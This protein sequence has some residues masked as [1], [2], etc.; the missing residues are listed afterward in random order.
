MTYQEALNYL[1]KETSEGIKPDLARISY[2]CH[3]L[4][5]PQ[6][7]YPTIHITGTN[8]KTTTARL[9]SS[10]LSVP[11]YKVGVFT[12]P[13]LVSYTERMVVEGE[14]IAQTKFAKGIE[15]LIP[16]FEET[17][18]RCRDGRLTQFEALT[19]LA[20]LFFQ[21]EKVDCAVVETGMGGSWDATN[22]VKA[23]VALITNVSLEHTDRLGNTVEEIA[24]EK[25]GII[26]K[27]STVITGVKEENLLRIIEGKC[28]EMDASLKILGR[29]FNILKRETNSDGSQVLT[30]K[31]LYGQYD[32][33]I[34]PLIGFYQAENA[35]LATAVSESFLRQES[36]SLSYPL[37]AE[38]LS[39]IRS[40]GRLEIIR[41]NPCLAL[42]GAHNPA[43]AHQ[44]AK[45]LKSEFRYGKLIVVLSILADKDVEG[46]LRELIP[47]ASTVVVSQNKD[48]R[49]LEAAKLA[50]KLDRLTKNE[51]LSLPEGFVVEKDLGKAIELALTRAS[52][53]DM[54]LV[55]GSLYTVGEAKR[56]LL[57][58]KN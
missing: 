57:R 36:S 47:V 18:R 23:K 22:M 4:G 38:A 6:L 31:G 33:L 26:K 54:V 58:T 12:S 46:I 50:E 24:F 28:R 9:I 17:N 32:G 10:I 48:P 27:D 51:G 8:G 30:I 14:N 20:F 25:A 53:K 43:G 45:A 39:K 35:A 1:E 2:L 13:H 42:D 29:D 21:D 11:G 37:L 40:P 44:L 34:L 56:H 55:T 16:Y 19:A 52:E 41:E 15:R 5:S 3:S 49:A 7:S